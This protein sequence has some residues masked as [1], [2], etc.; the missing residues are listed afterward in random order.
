MEASSGT[1]AISGDGQAIVSGLAHDTVRRWDVHTRNPLGDPMEGEGG[2]Y[3]LHSAE[4][5]GRIEGAD[6]GISGFGVLPNGTAVHSAEHAQY[7]WSE[8]KRLRLR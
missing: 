7:L 3:L 8:L 4:S 2:W 5:A 6:A 1:V